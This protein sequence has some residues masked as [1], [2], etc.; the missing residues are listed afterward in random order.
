MLALDLHGA[1]VF[2]DLTQRCAT[3]IAAE[4][5]S[6][7]ASVAETFSL[8]EPWVA[9]WLAGLGRRSQS[10]ARRAIPRVRAMIRRLSAPD[11]TTRAYHLTSLMRALDR[12]G[13]SE[14][15]EFEHPSDD[16]TIAELLAKLGKRRGA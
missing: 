15:A 4:R 2:G 9:V 14:P 13:E 16:E 6:W 10:A 7:V 1:R 8:H 12:F 5:P 11:A 3:R